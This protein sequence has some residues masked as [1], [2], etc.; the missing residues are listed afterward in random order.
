[1]KIIAAGNC[2]N[3]FTPYFEHQDGALLNKHC[4]F[5]DKRLGQSVTLTGR[6][7]VKHM[8]SHINEII[9]GEYDFYG[10]SIVYGDSVTGDTMIRTD[11]GDKTIEQLFN[12]CREHIISGTKEYGVWSD[13]KVVGFSSYYMEPTTSGI[14]YVM[15]HKTKK[16][17]YKITTENG[18]TVTVTEDHSVMVDRDGELLECR[19]TEILETDLIITF[20]P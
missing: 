6:Q 18:K 7:V 9:S 13:A 15:R 19:P 1:M 2:E 12:E 17:L 20:S 11:D 4:R 16:K 8:N 14:E 3:K 10:E 5:Y